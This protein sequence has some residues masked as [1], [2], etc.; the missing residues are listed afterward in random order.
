MQVEIKKCLDELKVTGS[1]ARRDFGGKIRELHQKQELMW[2]QQSQ[3]NS[4]QH[5]DWNSTS[6]HQRANS[7]RKTN[8]IVEAR[9]GYLTMGSRTWKTLVHNI[10]QHSFSSTNP[11]RMKEAICYMET[12]ITYEINERFIGC[13]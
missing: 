5:G 6:F 7:R 1:A 4:L 2:W 9:M 3:I 10:F 12:M 13:V 11:T 8:V